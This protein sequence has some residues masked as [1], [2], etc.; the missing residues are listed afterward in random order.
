MLNCF[1]FKL[2]ATAVQID[3]DMVVELLVEYGENA[4]DQ[5]DLT[6]NV[7]ARPE[8][9]MTNAFL[10]TVHL[11]AKQDEPLHEQ[12]NRVFSALSG[13]RTFTT[14]LRGFIQEQLNQNS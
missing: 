1:A 8:N 7:W 2:P 9:G 5:D 13:N 3:S 10:M 14:A 12:M 11:P 4:A 6:A